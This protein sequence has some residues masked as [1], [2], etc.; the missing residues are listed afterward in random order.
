MLVIE[1]TQ[2]AILFVYILRREVR[3]VKVTEICRTHFNIYTN[4]ILRICIEASVRR[5]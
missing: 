1:A 5:F 3:T 2:L 4:F